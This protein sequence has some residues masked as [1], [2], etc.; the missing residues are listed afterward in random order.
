MPYSPSVKHPSF[1]HISGTHYKAR[2]EHDHFHT[3]IHVGQI[4]DFIDFNHHLR[5]N[6]TLVGVESIPLGF[7]DFVDIWNNGVSSDDT[8]RFSNYFWEEDSEDPTFEFSSHPLTVSDFFIT[9]EQAGTNNP[10]PQP[11]ISDHHTDTYAR[12][13]ADIM[14][15]QRREGNAG[16]DKNNNQRQYHKKKGC[17]N[18]YD[19]AQSHLHFAKRVPFKSGNKDRHNASAST[20]AAAASTTGSNA[21]IPLADAQDIPV[22]PTNVPDDAMNGSTAW[23]SSNCPPENDLDH[24]VVWSISDLVS[25]CIVIFFFYFRFLSWE[26]SFIH[27]FTCPGGR[28]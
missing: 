15:E 22:I 26:N 8:R 13:L 4:V 12:E 11:Q 9:Q 17:A 10:R 16:H 28:M 27:K 7:L 2:G 1:F 14:V 24:S 3:T 23:Q 5:K 25:Y 18:R 20:S 19:V 21:S 6:K